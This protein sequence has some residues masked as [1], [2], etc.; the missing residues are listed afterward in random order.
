MNILRPLLAWSAIILVSFLA[1]APVSG[2]VHDWRNQRNGDLI[3]SNGYCDQP[4]VVVLK[5]RKW[6][7]VFTTG[8]SGE[9]SERQHIVSSNSQDQGKTWSQAVNIE[10][11]GPEAASWAMPYLT[12]YGRVYVFY[13]YNG[14][15]IHGLRDKQN[16]RADMLGWYCYKY[17]DNDGA[18]WSKRYRLP[19]TNKAVDRNNDWQGKVQIQWGIG[20]P[21]NVDKGMMFAFT[22][23]GRYMLDDSEGWFIRC[24]NINT[25]KNPGKL[26]WKQLPDG[27]AGLK[28][29]AL[30][31]IN[32][33][34]NIFQMK[35][36]S[37][38][39]MERTISGH[40]AEAYSRDGGK[41]W[42]VPQVPKYL[43]GIALKNPRACPRIW[44]CKNGKYLFW[45]HNNGSWKFRPS[46]NPAWVSG[47]IEKNGE[48]Q[49][50]QPEILLYEEDP[51]GRMSYPDLVEQ[52]GRYWVT[53]TNKEQA[54]CN[55]IPVTFLQKLWSQSDI[56]DSA[57]DGLVAT[58]NT[59]QL[60][61]DTSFTIDKQKYARG[62]TVDMVLELGDLASGQE[63]LTAGTPGGKAVVLR[64]GDYGSIEIIISDGVT[65]D[66]W[67]S[68]PGLIPAFGSHE[69]TVIVDNGPKII[70]FV[71]DGIV[72]N[73]RDFRQYGWGRY[74]ANMQNFVFGNIRIGQFAKGMGRPAGNLNLLRLY[75][76][77]LMNTE[78]I[79]NYRSHFDTALQTD[80]LQT[81]KK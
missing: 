33:E 24:D 26:L 44:K 38:Y 5:N 57:T 35:D 37:I 41:S 63:V 58:W 22:K 66:K 72:C 61:P 32:A 3:Y 74:T 18:T 21:V 39:C 77:P 71:V 76:R 30:G 25:E 54:K 81:W 67:S 53:E 51:D 65:T 6:L 7:V 79:G 28:N 43:N 1:L 70:Q 69:V 42:T 9:G 13:D 36:G 31:P 16:I 80:H 60:R 64:T 14:D 10:E 20:K 40:P 48:I 15:K 75:N 55:E 50:S 4:Y 59:N 19:I 27:D 73:G 68:D 2:Q 8:A 47:G 56:H 78:A 17:S 49:W 45:Y 12:N 52:D 23:I 11:P 34:Q 62:F 46:R 29:K